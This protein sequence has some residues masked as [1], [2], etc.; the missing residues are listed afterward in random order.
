[1]KKTLIIITV[2]ILMATSIV[3]AADIPKK[4]N[5]QGYVETTSGIPL[6]G[7]VYFK[8]SIIDNPTSP[9][10]TYWCND[11]T[12]TPAG[13]YV[14]TSY[15]TVPVTNGV[16]TVK[17]GA[18]G[19]SALTEAVFQNQNVYIR[20][21]F[22][23]DSSTFEQMSP[24]TQ[25][26]S[27]AFAYKAQTVAANAITSSAIE[28]GSITSSDIDSTNL[29]SDT[30]DGSDSTAFATSGHS[31]TVS[32]T[33]VTN[34]PAG[35]D[36]GDDVGS[37]SGACDQT[38]V[39]GFES[40]IAILEQIILTHFSRTGDDIYITGANL[41]VRSGGSST[42]DTVDGTGNII[43]GFNEPQ[44]LSVK[45]GSHNLIVGKNHNYSSYGGIVVGIENTISAPYASVSGGEINT[46]SGITSSVTGGVGNTAS[47]VYSSISGGQFNTASGD[48]SSVSG[49]KNHS[50]TGIDDWQAGTLFETE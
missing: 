30:L 16:F 17:L 9:T 32:W 28:D 3:L 10:T 40:R 18:T 22:S 47:G 23:D 39:N 25:I 13:T 45:T 15:V 43:I 12:G 7:D 44:S 6:D 8:F 41:N 4:M 11:C 50:I 2:I 34:R 24:D 19:M 36:D 48:N 38:C 27:S 33:D 31:H 46:A 26:L 49:G 1:M 35:L 29:D 14:P 5:Y 37:G 21:W 42:I 20:V